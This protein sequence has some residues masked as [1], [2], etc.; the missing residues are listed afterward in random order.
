MQQVSSFLI[1]GC[2]LH[3]CRVAAG[4]V[5][6]LDLRSSP[7]VKVAAVPSWKGSDLY[8]WILPWK[9]VS[10]CV[11]LTKRVGLGIPVHV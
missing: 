7:G 4:P 1:I 10:G 11:T 6:D 8:G 3:S 2:L 5:W 9:N